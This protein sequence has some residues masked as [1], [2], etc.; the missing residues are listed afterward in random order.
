M[1][2]QRPGSLDVRLPS[3][4]SL[5]VAVHA[6]AGRDVLEVSA[7][8]GGVLG[9]FDPRTASLF[10]IDP[11]DSIAVAAAVA[12]YLLGAPQPLG[13][14]S[15]RHVAAADAL[16]AI[17]EANP[18]TWQR[19]VPLHDRLLFFYCPI[20]H[21]ALEVVDDGEEMAQLD[22]PRFGAPGVMV[23]GIALRDIE[24]RPG[25]VASWLSALC[26]RRAGAPAGGASGSPDVELHR[27]LW[28]RLTRGG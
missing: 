7:A 27:S 6:R 9:H 12:P 21:L 25:V 2:D 18:F 24:E 14:V 20:A 5:V 17:L 26:T 4:S 28:M 11:Q 3:A 16:W 8:T 10:V 22:A 23:A 15:S 13:A 1:T 19:N